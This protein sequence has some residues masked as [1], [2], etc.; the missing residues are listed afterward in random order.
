MTNRDAIGL[1]RQQLT[2]RCPQGNGHLPFDEA[3]AGHRYHRD[4]ASRPPY[5]DRIAGAAD[6]EHRQVSR[7]LP[8][9]PKRRTIIPRR[10]QSNRHARWSE[11]RMRSGR[12]SCTCQEHAQQRGIEIDVRMDEHS[13]HPSRVSARE[14]CRTRSRPDSVS[15]RS[16][17]RPPVA[18]SPARHGQRRRPALVPHPLWCS[19][20]ASHS[21]RGYLER[22]RNGRHRNIGDTPRPIESGALI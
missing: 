15:G 20:Q 2:R 22:R 3:I 6:A 5:A 19:G 18:T 11:R 8:T 21:E 10:R 17:S 16:I 4:D 9:D 7:W 13:F 12:K 14:L 1:L